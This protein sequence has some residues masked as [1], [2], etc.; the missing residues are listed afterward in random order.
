MA[1][2]DHIKQVVEAVAQALQDFQDIPVEAD[3]VAQA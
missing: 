1:D 3:P 2:L